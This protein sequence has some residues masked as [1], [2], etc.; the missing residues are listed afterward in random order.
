MFGNSGNNNNNYSSAGFGRKIV[1]D[2]F[3][4][5]SA[6]LDLKSKNPFNASGGFSGGGGGGNFGSNPIQMEEFLRIT[7]ER[8]NL[9][10]FNFARTGAGGGD[11]G[12]G[13]S[14]S[15]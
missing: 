4:G 12:G 1:R 8:K 14:G 11:L 13:A 2:K 9:E 6:D 7:G 10:E 15:F 3:G 5:A